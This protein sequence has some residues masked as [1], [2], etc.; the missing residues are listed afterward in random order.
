MANATRV[1]DA[2]KTE[3]QDAIRVALIWVESARKWQPYVK[4]LSIR[5]TKKGGGIVDN[6]PMG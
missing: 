2:A 5:S 3:T 6:P 4:T 1:N